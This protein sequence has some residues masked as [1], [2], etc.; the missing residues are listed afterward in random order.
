MNQSMY[1]SYSGTKNE[2]PMGAQT[3][4]RCPDGTST[5][6]AGSALDECLACSD[7]VR[8]TSN[9]PGCVVETS[10]FET[11]AVIE[12]TPAP[13]VC[14]NG[15]KV[16]GSIEECDD[17]NLVNGDG[18]SSECAIEVGFKCQ[19]QGAGLAMMCYLSCGD[20]KLDEG[21]ETCDDG[22]RDDGDGCTSL[23]FV[24]Q[25]WKCEVLAG[26]L[27]SCELL[28]V[29]G[30][31]VR[32]WEKS[33]ECDDGDLF[34]GDGCSNTC[35]IEPGYTCSNFTFRSD[36]C[37]ATLELCGNGKTLF[38]AIISPPLHPCNA[39]TNPYPNA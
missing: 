34:S 35:T 2:D 11:N 4:S 27:S 36:L 13:D 14:G 25:G 10:L 16:P 18:C 29:C 28:S 17:G 32:E 33:E 26:G 24:D 7:L 1:G 38:E 15:L 20:G 21:R 12:T 6:S 19:E 31:Q 8:I 30:N 5:L 39:Y 37:C 22:N 3:C 9:V 23:C